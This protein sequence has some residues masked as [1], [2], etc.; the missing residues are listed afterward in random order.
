LD[1][2]K[3]E[4]A[5]KFGF[6]VKNFKQFFL[7]R[8]SEPKKRNFFYC[9]TFSPSCTYRLQNTYM[10]VMRGPISKNFRFDI[11][12]SVSVSEKNCGYESQSEKNL[13][14]PQRWFWGTES[15]GYQNEN[16]N[17]YRY[18]YQYCA[19]TGIIIPYRYRYPHRR[20]SCNWLIPIADRAPKIL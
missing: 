17:T 16:I 19:S 7:N 6:G 4:S 3:P 8:R 12:V 9:K 5:K 10:K 14:H 11:L 18:Q 1:G 2:S 15:V 20:T 13:L